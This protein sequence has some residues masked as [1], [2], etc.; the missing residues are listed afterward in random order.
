MTYEKI[1][2]F[3]ISCRVMQESELD[4]LTIV[5]SPKGFGKSS[6]IINAGNIYVQFFGLRCLSCSHIWM[7]TGNALITSGKDYTVKPNLFEPCPV[8]GCQSIGRVD[9]IDFKRYLAYDNEDVKELI[10]TLPAFSPL[11]PD[12]GVRFLMGE[13]WM[14]T[15]NKELKK[16]FAQMRTKRL[17]VFTNIPKFKWLDSKYRNDMTTF[18]IRILQRGLVILMQPDLGED[19]D[20]WHMKEF[21]KKLKSYFYFTPR[22]VLLKRAEDLKKN[23]PTVFDYFFV[24]KVPEHIYQKYLEARDAKVFERKSKDVNLDQKEIAKIAAWNLMENWDKIIGAIKM[25][26][27]FQKPTLKILERFVFCHPNTDEPIIRYTT[28]RNWLQTISRAIVRK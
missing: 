26:S 25:N 15:E 5:S 22:E 12:E 19:D 16:L 17:L 3:V 18:W 14:L 23:V 9:E 10:Y 7:Y 4:V 11:L 21:Q 13:D 20:P 8:C 27:R 24:P 28:I 6:L 1:K 2:Q